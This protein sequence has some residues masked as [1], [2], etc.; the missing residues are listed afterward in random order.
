MCRWHTNGVG[1][2]GLTKVLINDK[3]AQVAKIFMI[4][5]ACV[6][7]TKDNTYIFWSTKHL[8]AKGVMFLS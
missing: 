4:N 8:V 3:V 6:R 2:Q 7:P 5:E 1:H